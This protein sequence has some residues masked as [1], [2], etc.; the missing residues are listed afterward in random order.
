MEQDAQASG[1][2]ALAEL[3]HRVD[4]ARGAIIAQARRDLKHLPEEQ[5]ALEKRLTAAK[6][7]G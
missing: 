5:E 4:E 2:R 7:A 3:T 6:E 1:L